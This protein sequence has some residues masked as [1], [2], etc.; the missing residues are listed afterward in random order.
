[1]SLTHEVRILTVAGKFEIEAAGRMAL[2][3]RPEAARPSD[4]G[5]VVLGL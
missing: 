3:R 1:M 2:H 4:V 5:I